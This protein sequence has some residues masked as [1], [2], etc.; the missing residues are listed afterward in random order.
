MYIYIFICICVYIYIH[1][2]TAR[3][4]VLPG[5]V[6]FDC[7]G[8]VLYEIRDVVHLPRWMTKFVSKTRNCRPQTANPKP[9]NPNL[10]SS[11]KY[12]LKVKCY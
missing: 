9:L 1:T 2:A 6:R 10:T 11:P 7:T 3:T 5:E 4:G 8:P 12:A